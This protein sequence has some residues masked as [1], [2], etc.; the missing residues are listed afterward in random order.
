V[1]LAKSGKPPLRKRNRSYFTWVYGKVPEV[2]I[3]VVSNRKGG[4]EDEKLELYAQLGILYYVIHDP[5]HRLS[6]ETLRL[7]RLS[8]RKYQPLKSRWLAKIELGLTLWRGEYE[9]MTVEWLRWC[10]EAGSVIPTGAERA[11]QQNQRAERLAD[12]LRQLGHDPDA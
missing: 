9:G 8:G 10:D 4:E 1:K 2:S 6:E 3:E 12:K 5:Y 11:D 7:L